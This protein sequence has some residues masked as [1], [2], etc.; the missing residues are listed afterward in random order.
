M[1]LS[2]H[3][4]GDKRLAARE[5]S[6]VRK[7]DTSEKNLSNSIFGPGIGGQEHRVEEVTFYLDLLKKIEHMITYSPNSDF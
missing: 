5:R 7:I 3:G 1:F 6:E 2:S 4:P